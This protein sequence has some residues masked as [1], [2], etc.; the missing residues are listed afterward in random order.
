MTTHQRIGYSD[1][2]A[3]SERRG[4]GITR[5]SRIVL[6][7]IL[8]PS[9]IARGALCITELLRGRYGSDEESSRQSG[10]GVMP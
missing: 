2:V 4:A 1:I 5:C 7:A 10:L 9:Y 3:A 8:K 6:F